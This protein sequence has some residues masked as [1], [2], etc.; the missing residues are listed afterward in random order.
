M[1]RLI[2]LSLCALIPTPAMSTNWCPPTAEAF[3]QWGWLDENEGGDAWMSTVWC[4]S[5]IEGQLYPLPSRS[6]VI[7]SVIDNMGL[8]AN[9]SSEWAQLMSDAAACQPN[10]WSGRLVNGAYAGDYVG[11]N[12]DQDTFEHFASPGATLP[13]GEVVKLWL[14]QFVRYYT[15]PHGWEWYCIATGDLAGSN[16]GWTFASNPNN[17]DP[18]AL[19]F[20]WFWNLNAADRAAVLVH[21]GAHEFIGHVSDS[22]C[23]NRGS[24]DNFYGVANAQSFTI[25]VN[26]QS[27]DAYRR[28]AG[29][30]ELEIYNYGHDICGYVALLPDAVRWG[31]VLKMRD[32]LLNVFKFP[33]PESEWPPAAF[34]DTVYGSIYD[35]SDEPNGTPG[36]A[37]RIDIV[38]GARWPCSSV[39]DPTDYDF[40]S[41]GPR[42]C[43]EAYQPENVAINAQNR[44]L[45]VAL[46]Q[47]VAAGV[48]PKE[49]AQL[50]NRLI[51]ESARC[52]SGVSAAYVDQVCQQLSAQAAHVGDIEAAWS[53]PDQGFYFDASQAIA[54]CQA[55]FCAARG[56]ATW[57]NEARAACYEWD[58]DAGCLALACGDRAAV[59]AKH[60]RDSYEYLESLVCRAS[61]LG[62]HFDGLVADPSGCSAEYQEC[63]IRERYLPAWEAQLAGGACWS[64]PS[65]AVYDP[66]YAEVRHAAGTL[67][68][69]P[70]LALDRDSHLVNS[71]CMIV[72]VSC[73]AQQAALRAALARLIHD[74]AHTR[75]AWKR[76]TLPDR[77]EELAGRYDREVLEVLDGLGRDLADPLISLGILARNERI[78]RLVRSPEAAVAIA[79]LAGHDTYLRAGGA[80]F[81]RGVFAPAQLERYSVAE[82][83]DPY[84]LSTTGWEVELSALG[85]LD[86]SLGSPQGREAMSKAPTL[87]GPEAYAHL[88]ALLS[89]KDG[90]A[91]EQAFE[92]FVVD[93]AGR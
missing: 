34:V 58:D 75:P 69:E 65:A 30:R 93:V 53:I 80:R 76:P 74:K 38:N 61:Q 54:A 25:A 39:C 57:A 18:M 88:V 62:R 6:D 33:P 17:D 40:A 7:N 73:E 43:N 83:A 28:R 67:A 72:E 64:G 26:A 90:V 50:Q 4:G 19:Y 79:E 86:L 60:G 8:S 66:L 84:A 71:K 12:R 70:F 92:A 9:W 85:Q 77:W 13:G 32:R 15:R 52:I 22:A 47:E 37:Y 56:G 63:I 31:L 5:T 87:S 82:T 51:L 78:G 55:S 46:N 42:A 45:C 27:L 44:G 68:V 41:S 36:L 21:E 35:L 16:D 24:C 23:T 10:S 3:D 81:A 49:R 2:L 91:L 14:S 59:E 48:T 11:I 1:N 20:P 29:S 89:A